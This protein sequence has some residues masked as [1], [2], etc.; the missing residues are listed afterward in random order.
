[1]KYPD[2]EF[3][4]FFTWVNRPK[5]MYSPGL[6]SEL[7]YEMGELGGN[8]VVIYTDKGLVEAGVTEM[9]A[10]EVRN[11]DLELVGIFD[12]I[13]QDARI[14]S[15][16]EG[17]EFYRNK[18]ADSMVVVGGG[19]VMDTAKAI[20]IMAG[21]GHDDF[22]PLAEQGALWDEARPLPPHIAF[23]THGRDSL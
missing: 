4:P 9:V 10:E 8:K 13:I 23:P 20:N 3:E 5:I 17:A 22:Q 21:E 12:K 7:G 16:N 2:I 1:M 11:S 14:D 19:S 18:G 6:R 15:I